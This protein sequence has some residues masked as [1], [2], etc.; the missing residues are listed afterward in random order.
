M[1]ALFNIKK[2]QV[3]KLTEETD[4][5]YSYGTP[6]K[7][8]G[9]VSLSMDIEQTNETIYADGVS[10]ITLQGA[11]TTTGTLENYHIPEEVL[12]NIYNYVKSTTGEILQTDDAVN[13]MGMQFACDD[14]AGNEVY[15]TYYDVTSTKPSLSL[16]TRE[17]GVTV[18]AESVDLTANS[19]KVGDKNVIRSYATKDMDA[20]ENYFDKVNVPTI[21]SI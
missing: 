10:Y 15:F 8:P 18:N 21:A 1:K 12:L 20:Y 3:S 14:D 19:I 2:L 4:G 9:T 17:D 13:R 6:I 5:N 7:V 16:Q 11:A